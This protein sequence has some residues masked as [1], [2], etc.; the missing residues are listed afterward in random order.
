MGV[1][2]WTEDHRPRGAGLLEQAAHR[3]RGHL[4]DPVGIALAE[5]ARTRKGGC[6][7][8]MDEVEGK[9]VTRL[10]RGDPP[11]WLLHPVLSL[12]TFRVFDELRRA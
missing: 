2:P 8:R 11:L 9:L 10:K 6:L 1:V 5:Q 4:A 7:G 12:C 3:V